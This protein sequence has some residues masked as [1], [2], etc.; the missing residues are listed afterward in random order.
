MALSIIRIPEKLLR[1]PIASLGG[2]RNPR[3]L[4]EH[5]VFFAQPVSRSGRSSDFSEVT[6]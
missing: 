1:V 6:L 2:E 5:S 3:R 4:F